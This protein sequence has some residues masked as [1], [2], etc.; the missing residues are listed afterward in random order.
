MN[1]GYI[2]ININDAQVGLKFGMS[3]NRMFFEH[4]G[5]RYGESGIN[6]SL[7]EIDISELIFAG[8]KNNCLIKD[9]NPILT[10]GQIIEWVDEMTVNNGDILL[11]ITKVWEQSKFSEKYIEAIKEVLDPEAKKKLTG[12]I[13]NPTHLVY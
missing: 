4:L 9:L 13:S 1:N 6:F 5:K 8:Y 7:N 2:S 10:R 3:A 12:T 11:D